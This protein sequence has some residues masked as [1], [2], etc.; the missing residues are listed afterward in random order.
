MDMAHGFAPTFR[1]DPSSD[2]DID[3]VDTTGDV[4][5]VQEHIHQI[6][7]EMGLRPIQRQQPGN[8]CAKKA[9]DIT[10]LCLIRLAWRRELD[11][12]STSHTRL[13]RTANEKLDCGLTHLDYGT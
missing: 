12:D 4:A 13:R 3:D 7:L 11:Q 6:R 2:V 1:H 8:T 9:H 10:N 5:R